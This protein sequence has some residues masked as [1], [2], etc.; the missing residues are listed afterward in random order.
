MN[1][2]LKNVNGKV[3]F[4]LRTEKDFVKNQMSVA[5]ADHIIN[6]GAVTKSDRKDYPICVDDKWFFE[7][8]ILPKKKTGQK[9][10]AE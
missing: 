5:S 4:L 9:E 7:G 8:E 2:K 6:T 3:N 1:F 10:V